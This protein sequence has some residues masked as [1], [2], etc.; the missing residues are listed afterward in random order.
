VAEASTA[1]AE[2]PADALRQPVPG[3]LWP[4]VKRVSWAELGVFAAL[5]LFWIAPGF[6]TETMI[7][8]WAHGI[9]FIGL[10]ALIWI[11]YLRRQVPLWLLGATLTPVGPVG[12]VIG[13][14]AIE[15]RGR[16]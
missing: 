15:R 13:I 6:E 2:R 16:A 3:A 9:G 4:W 12:S 11:A 1:S 8:G 14:G 10:V 5:L 7:A